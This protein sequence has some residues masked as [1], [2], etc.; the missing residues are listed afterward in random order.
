MKPAAVWTTNILLPG[1]GLIL[2]GA[3][4]EG[5]ALGMSF[6]LLA[7]MSIVTTWVAPESYHP[8][9]RGLLWLCTGAVFLACQ[10]RLPAAAG[11]LAGEQAAGDRRDSLIRAAQAMQ[12][13]R[14]NE[15]CDELIRAQRRFPNDLLVAV[16]LAEALEAAGA[17]SEAVQA[18]RRVRELDHH[19]IY[20]ERGLM[21]A[22]P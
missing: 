5:L 10:L 9:A 17:S 6:S 18:W 13:Q 11:R 21:R 14:W 7:A 15:A 4:V 16:R 12:A 3:L 19:H 2:C 22:T 1:G 8:V 20:R